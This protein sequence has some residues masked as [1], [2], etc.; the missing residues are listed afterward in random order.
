MSASVI[1]GTDSDDRR[2]VRDWPS[3]GPPVREWCEVVEQEE[4]LRRF[5]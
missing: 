5:L 2:Q 4:R 3:R 1:A